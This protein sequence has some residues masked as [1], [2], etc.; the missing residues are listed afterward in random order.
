MTDGAGG[1]SVLWR[2]W[3]LDRLLAMHVELVDAQA[4]AE[5]LRAALAY[6]TQKHV[7][8]RD[9]LDAR[10]EQGEARLAAHGAQIAT[11]I[12]ERDALRAELT[13]MAERLEEASDG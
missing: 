7:V 1:L 11:L 3:L 2:N 6:E 12:D 13:E 9:L 5:D 8:E 4:T 10:R